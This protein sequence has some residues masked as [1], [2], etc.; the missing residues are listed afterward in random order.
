MHMRRDPMLPRQVRSGAGAHPTEI[1]AGLTDAPVAPSDTAVGDTSIR[2]GA[3]TAPA[4]R[5]ASVSEG[6]R[7]RRASRAHSAEHG[8]Q[9]RALRPGQ[10]APCPALPAPEQ[11]RRAG[12]APAAPRRTRQGCTSSPVAPT[13]ARWWWIATDVP[14][15]FTNS[16]SCRWIS[17][18][19]AGLSFSTSCRQR[20]HQPWAR[21]RVRSPPV[22]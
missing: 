19:S 12:G 15:T 11:A 3:T 18:P 9:Q 2:L 10:H 13:P 4:A 1:S 16:G 14:C 8:A 22:G 7:G 17:P 5:R 20:T 21:C 6:A